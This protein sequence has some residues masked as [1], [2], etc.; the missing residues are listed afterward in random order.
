MAA[1]SVCHQ[2]ATVAAR[3]LETVNVTLSKGGRLQP[4]VDV[5]LD[6]RVQKE[7]IFRDLEQRSELDVQLEP[8][9]ELDVSLEGRTL[10]SLQEL[11]ELLEESLRSSSHSQ[12]KRNESVFASGI[13]DLVEPLPQIT[14]STFGPIFLRSYFFWKYFP[15]EHFVDDLLD[16][17]VKFRTKL[18]IAFSTPDEYA[19]LLQTAIQLD[20]VGLAQL[21]VAMEPLRISNKSCLCPATVVAKVMKCASTLE[22]VTLLLE[23]CRNPPFDQPSLLPTSFNG[24]PWWRSMEYK[25]ADLFLKHIGTLPHF[26]RLFGRGLDSGTDKISDT[27][28]WFGSDIST[29][30]DQNQKLPVSDNMPFASNHGLTSMEQEMIPSVE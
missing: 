28:K 7:T 24:S 21:V 20:Y 2:F 5:T 13:Q 25:Y 3:L 11:D 26:R 22:V 18:H 6:I 23:I 15:L 14:V 1:P 4:T 29:S 27:M 17:V 9:P 19:K 30:Y 12:E 10:R 8:C 16:L